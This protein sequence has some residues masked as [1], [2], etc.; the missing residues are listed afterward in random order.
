MNNGCFAHGSI[1]QLLPLPD[2]QR[3]SDN[4]EEKPISSKKLL[5]WLMNDDRAQGFWERYNAHET[6]ESLRE[7]IYDGELDSEN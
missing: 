2:D 3:T 1:R 5:D 4:K 6:F 7:A